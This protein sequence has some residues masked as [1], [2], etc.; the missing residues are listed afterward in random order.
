MQIVHID[1]F[2]IHVIEDVYGKT[3]SELS[4]CLSPNFTIAP[5]GGECHTSDEQ[6]GNGK[7]LIGRKQFISLYYA[8]VL[9]S[10]SAIHLVCISFIQISFEWGYSYSGDWPRAR[11]VL[12]SGACFEST[13]RT[14]VV[15]DVFM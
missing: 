2:P 8:E 6:D 15:P 12:Y 14:H 11:R 1:A 7:S 9:I 4:D 10:D 3:W 13:K 5:H